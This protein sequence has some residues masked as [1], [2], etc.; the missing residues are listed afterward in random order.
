MPTRSKLVLFFVETMTTKLPGAHRPAVRMRAPKMHMVLGAFAPS[1]GD[2]EP[3]AAKRLYRSL[4]V[5]PES[6]RRR[7][8]SHKLT[9]VVGEVA[10]HPAQ[11]LLD[12]DPFEATH[13]RVVAH[14]QQRNALAVELL[15][16]A[17]GD[18][19]AVDRAVF[20]GDAQL[21]QQLDHRGRF[22]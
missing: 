8:M 19:V 2:P 5:Y 12:L 17:H 4:W 7:Q 20:E 3:A 10:A 11:E 14:A 18:R 22:A 16:L 21:V 1:P 9:P 13:D 6:P 15:P